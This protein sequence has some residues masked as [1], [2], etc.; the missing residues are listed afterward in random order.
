MVSNTPQQA[1]T[2]LND[3]AFVEAA[4]V[5]AARL[6]EAACRGDEERLDWAFERAV[7]RAPREKEKASLL[8]F[9]AAQ[10]EHYGTET[11]AAG[12]LA[13]VGNAPAPKN[14]DGTELT[15]WTQACRVILNLQETI[16]RY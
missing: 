9:L 6:L 13:H 3:P 12:K 1:L 7:A 5:F 14:L 10:R 8:G 4:R 2:L 11:E 16:T 15:A